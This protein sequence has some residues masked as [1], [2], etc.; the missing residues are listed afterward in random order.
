MLLS[1][2][3]APEADG[4]DDRRELAAL[5]AACA[6]LAA[7]DDVDPERVA[8]VGLG[9]A[10]TLA[11][12]HGCHSDAAFAVASLGG[13]LARAELSAARPMQP[14]EMALN[15]SCPALLLVAEGDPC[16]GP[17][18]VAHARRVLTQF[19]RSFELEPLPPGGPAG[20]GALVRLRRFLESA[21]G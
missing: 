17:E 7:R 8:V 16:A 12:L 5:D 11:F 21:A 20:A 4:G 10:G 2:P 6:W 9:A 13:P 18:V 15:L 3:F 14:L 1:D 19:A